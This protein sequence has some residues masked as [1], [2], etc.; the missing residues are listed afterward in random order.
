M[1]VSGA[2]F[3]LKRLKTQKVEL[4]FEGENLVSRKGDFGL[5]RLGN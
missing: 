1:K 5:K 3:G 4:Y 2:L